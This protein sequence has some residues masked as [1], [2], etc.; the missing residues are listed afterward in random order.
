MLT[1]HKST[2]MTIKKMTLGTDK[3]QID[4]SPEPLNIQPR[5]AMGDKISMA[6]KGKIIMLM[7]RRSME[8]ISTMM[9]MTM[10][11][12]GSLLTR[13]ILHVQSRYCR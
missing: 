9:M 10:V 8:A 1:I 2:T 4:H 12:C 5:M 3:D 13:F 11:K 7:A 6:V